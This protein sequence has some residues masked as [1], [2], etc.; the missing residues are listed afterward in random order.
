MVGRGKCAHHH[1]LLRVASWATGAQACRGAPPARILC[2][3][4]SC[5]P[6]KFAARLKQG[7]GFCSTPLVAMLKMRACHWE[8]W[9]LTGWSLGLYVSAAFLCVFLTVCWHAA[10][11]VQGPV[12]EL[13]QRRAN[14][15]VPLPGG[16]RLRRALRQPVQGWR[17]WASHWHVGSPAMSCYFMLHMPLRSWHCQMSVVACQRG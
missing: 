17:T 2:T 9:K 3:C 1:L 4:H 13:E 7:C 12:R 10:G 5:N 8:G 11:A 16:V 15:E 14:Q 6:G